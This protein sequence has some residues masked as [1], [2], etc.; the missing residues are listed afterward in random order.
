MDK[1]ITNRKNKNTKKVLI[2][3]AVGVVLIFLILNFSRSKQVNLSADGLAIKEVVSGEF[4]DVVLINSRVEP[5]T[6]VLVNVIQGGSVAEIFVESGRLVKKGTP[7]LKVYNPTAELSYLTQETAMIEQI[8]NLNNIRV[9]IKNQ[10]LNLDEQ[11]L[12]IDN[13]FK[14]AK[15]KYVMD[16]TLYS[17]GVI[18]RNDYD[19]SKQ[20][21]QFQK[22]RNEVIKKSAALEKSDSHVQ[23]NRLNTSLANMQ[24]SLELLRSNKD[25]FTVKAPI[26][27]FLSSFNPLLGSTYTQG[28]NIGKIDVLDGYKLTAKMDEYYIA[29]LQEGIEGTVSVN[30][31]NHGI[32]LTKIFSEV[33]NG[34]FEIELTFSKPDELS[35]VKRGMSLNAKLFLSNN[36][37]ALLLPKGMFYQSSNG[38]WVFVLDADNHA[39]KRSVKIGRENPFYYEVLEGLKAGDKVITSSYDDFEKMEEINIK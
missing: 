13:S 27:G 10:Q 16:S 30:G 5:K 3:L 37:K 14:N 33:V 38:Q 29:T 8:N 39:V 18:A 4:E 2:F 35:E 11:L 22:E 26:D 20:E 7:L 9:S 19:I 21:Y 12:S 31:K 15:R 36:S 34:Q 32:R 28:Q 23:L 25:N 17:K 6:S 1:Q 24:K